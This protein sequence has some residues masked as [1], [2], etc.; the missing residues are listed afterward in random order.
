MGLDL[1][2]VDLVEINAQIGILGFTSHRLMLGILL[3]TYVTAQYIL[4]EA[5]V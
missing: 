3:I 1:N 5:D 4:N 2:E